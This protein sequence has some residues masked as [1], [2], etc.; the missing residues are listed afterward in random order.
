MTDANTPFTPSEAKIILSIMKNLEGDIKADF[1]AVAVDCNLKDAN[2]AKTRWRQ[3]LCSK[4]LNNLSPS[5][6]TP[7]GTTGA[8]PSTT[9][10]GSPS[11]I[12]K[13][14]SPR[15]NK[16][17]VARARPRL[18]FADDDED[19]DEDSDFVAPRTITRSGRSAGMKGIVAATGN[20]NRKMIQANRKA[21]ANT[22]VHATTKGKGK[23]KVSVF[24]DDD[25]DEY[26]DVDMD[27]TGPTLT[28]WRDFGTEA[29]DGD[30]EIEADDEAESV[31]VKAQKKIGK[32]KGA[33]RGV[34]KA[35]QDEDE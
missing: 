23:G 25:D 6:N 32:G 31:G 7:T 35:E 5:S 8:G 2:I 21:H 19:E 10:A 14:K 26:Q 1:A 3:I 13:K 34:V 17:G 28:T 4:K 12:A 11:G 9:T 20:T 27:P 15:A 29:H 33:R 16:K 18:S 22:K 30:D 24:K